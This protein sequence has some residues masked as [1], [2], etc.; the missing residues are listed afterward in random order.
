MGLNKAVIIS[1]VCLVVV[2]SVGLGL[3]LGFGK[4]GNDYTIVASHGRE[5]DWDNSGNFTT[6]NNSSTGVDLT[7]QN[8]P[9]VVNMVVNGEAF[10][11]KMS[12]LQH[13]MDTYDRPFFYGHNITLG[14][15][16]NSDNVNTF[17]ILV[18]NPLDAE[19]KLVFGVDSPHPELFTLPADSYLGAK[20]YR[21]FNFQEKL[22]NELEVSRLF[23]DYYQYG[24]DVGRVYYGGS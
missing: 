6:V 14:Y 2:L 17:S 12:E 7:L 20:E 15:Q 5:V 23:F 13:A 4:F 16:S 11:I 3:A 18:Y 9:N 8:D 21:L 1:L 10:Y 19:V 24:K 22:L